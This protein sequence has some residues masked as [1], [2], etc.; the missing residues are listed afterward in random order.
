MKTSYKLLAG[1][2]V[3]LLMLTAATS[4]LKA[5]TSPLT[6]TIL[7]PATDEVLVAGS[8]YTIQWQVQGNTSDL[9]EFRIWWYNGVTKSYVGSGGSMYLAVV[10]A[11]QTSYN[12]TVPSAISKNHYFYI[13]AKTNDGKSYWSEPRRFTINSFSVNIVKPAVGESLVAGSQYTI[14]WQT[15]GD[16]TN[17]KEYW[18]YFYNA[19][20]KSFGSLITVPATQTSYNWTVPSDISENHYLY[21]GG[22][23]NSGDT[24]WSLYRRVTIIPASSPTVTITSPTNNAQLTAGSQVNITWR[25]D[26]GINLI[27]HYY[28]YF[29]DNNIKNYTSSIRISDRN[30][31]SY[32]WTVPNSVGSGHY[33]VI[34][35]Y[36]TTGPRVYS[37]YV[38]ISIVSS[39]TPTV[40]CSASPNPANV[41]QNVTWTATSSNF[42]GTP[43]YTWS[44]AVTGTGNPKTASYTTTGTK[45]ATVAATY[46]NQTATSTCSVEINSLKPDLYIGEVTTVSDSWSDSDAFKIDICNSGGV[47]SP[48]SVGI[49][50]TINGISP[51]GYG[52]MSDDQVPAPNKCGF[53]RVEYSYFKMNPGNTY[54]G[55]IIVD[56]ANIIDELNEQNNQKSFKITVPT[57]TTHKECQNQKCVTVSGGGRDWCQVNSDCTPTITI[58]SPTNNAQLIVYSQVNI[59]W[60]TPQPIPDY[61]SNQIIWYDG[62]NPSGELIGNTI[63]ARQQFTWTVPNK[64]GSG[65]KLVVRAVTS[66]TSVPYIDSDPVQFSIISP[67][68]IPTVSCSASPN[69][70]NV[71]QTVTWTATPGYFSCTPIYTW[72]GAVTGT[73]NSI[74]ATYT[75]S[76]TK[77]A[78][79][80]ASCGGQTATST[81]SVQ[82]NAAATPTV[83]CWAYPNP[84]NINGNVTW[85]ATPTNFS[86]TPT[87]T[88]SG[89]VS[90]TGNFKVTSYSS[91]GVKE[92]TVTATASGVSATS[93]CSVEIISFPTITITSPTNNAQLT[94]GSQVNITWAV[95][96]DTSRIA[97]F[98]LWWH[99]PNSTTD[100]ELVNN[101]SATSRSYTWTV[102]NS[103]NTGYSL[104]LLAD[105]TNGTM[106]IQSNRI[107]FSIVAVP[108]P[109]V[110]CSASPNPANVGQ[111]VTW[112]ATASN[113]SGTP[114][115]TWSGA[116]TGTGNLKTASYETT[117][118]KTATVTA[119]YG[120]QTATSTC[121]VN[122]TTTSSGATCTFSKSVYSVGEK[123]QATVCGSLPWAAVSWVTSLITNGNQVIKCVDQQNTDAT[124]C[125]TFGRC[126][127]YVSQGA[128]GYGTFYNYGSVYN[129]AFNCS[130]ELQ[131][132]QAT[133]T[134]SCSA[135]PNPANVGQTVTWTAS[136]SNFSGTPTYTW[137]GAVTGTGNPKT[138]SYETTGT[139]TA[140]VTATYGNQTA[141][142]TCSVNVTTTSVLC[143]DNTSRC[144]FVTS[145]IYYPTFGGVEGGDKICND[146]AKA[147]GLPGTYKAWLSGFDSTNKLAIN[148]SDRLEHSTLPYKLVTG[149]IV[150]NNWQELTTKPLLHAINI[151]E[152]G[153]KV[154][155]RWVWTGS[156]P[157]GA[158][159][160]A[161]LGAVSPDCS[162]W[163]ARYACCASCGWNDSTNNDP[164]GFDPVTGENIMP[165]SWGGEMYAR[166]GCDQQYHLYCFQQGSALGSLSAPLSSVQQ[167]I[168][169]QL[170][171]LYQIVVQLLQQIQALK[172][173]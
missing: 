23:T 70:A 117:G 155:P 36:P 164:R 2:A 42:S 115:Y 94:A 98:R 82:V 39:T 12:W 97:N 81:C 166:L 7:K 60:S 143:G 112:T 126:L 107:Q 13:Q 48:R 69:P 169:Q 57:Q 116:V 6:I 47:I 62:T 106:P 90:G 105:L 147:S 135:S 54:D 95:D 5:Q 92:A 119:T 122:I 84:Q 154:T 86:S 43:T 27:D 139:K 50:L 125:V 79:V 118:T 61:T 56:P 152:K 63:P 173:Q 77:M 96:G 30:Q 71:G 108:T 9:K 49:K 156:M 45:T 134:V 127:D 130:F 110:S 26:G 140:T 100:S 67:L 29:Y 142:S 160:P 28:L 158:R 161:T 40:S 159:T 104:W 1:L 37:P 137:S 113:F 146:L 136:A 53:V 15:Q 35:A 133:P 121:S 99:P 74:T 144:V 165:Q 124:G 149:E 153:Q 172:G 103:P 68:H 14:Q 25:V 138:A 131:S 4:T 111:T 148:V 102:P 21:V 20:K 89:A 41:G 22:R 73:G 11:T 101:I 46:G 91:S 85:T 120:N 167:S 128:Y 55:L 16:T 162:N 170:A 58:T 151:N 150:A 83:S 80:F 44:G 78:G 88:W 64:P 3:G 34:A 31:T 19:V 123:I 93:S 168:T 33:L 51:P 114:T 145:Q 8:Q 24:Y 157:N 66:N 87:Y 72:V 10:P 109:T 17:L 32:N 18:I 129:K 132:S 65:Y 75:T 141:T 59:T 163:N 171:N 76:G 52:Y 38:Y